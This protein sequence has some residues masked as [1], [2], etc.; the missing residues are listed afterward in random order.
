NTRNIED[1][2]LEYVAEQ[3]DLKHIV[4]SFNSV[5]YVDSSGLE[6]LEAL[7]VRLRDAGVTLHLAEVK[8]P[9]MDRFDKVGLT[10][11]LAPGQVFLSTHRAVVA[12]RGDSKPAE[13]ARAA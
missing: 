13:P 10:E 5:N 4:L 8:G 6:S 2:L 9:V 11:H 7:I 12:L 1:R 3:A